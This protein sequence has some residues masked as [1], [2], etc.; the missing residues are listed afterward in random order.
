[1][2]MSTLLQE[3]PRTG[4]RKASGFGNAPSRRTAKMPH[5]WRPTVTARTAHDERLNRLT[6]SV[7]CIPT[8]DL[9]AQVSEI[10]GRNQAT[11]VAEEEVLF[12]ALCLEDLALSTD[13]A[14]SDDPISSDVEAIEFRRNIMDRIVKQN[15]PLVHEMSRRYS[16]SGLDP[17]EFW[18]E[19]TLALYRAVKRYDPTRGFRFS[20][21]AC[22]SIL[23][24]FQSMERRRH[25][26]REAL[27]RFARERLG[28]VRPEGVEAGIDRQILIG[29]VSAI[30]S[31][32]EA[33][34]TEIERFVVE[35]RFLSVSNEGTRTLA[36]LGHALRLSKQRV[37]QIEGRALA[38][39]RT[40][41]CAHA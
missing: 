17:D 25:R 6:D 39:L 31:S 32:D 30:L 24:A 5:K 8:E 14:F 2:S 41:L 18:S 26:E 29:K 1:M 28:T 7:A 19:G 10:L 4:R 9:V 22:T 13:A 12:R 35:R 21:Y 3:A 16:V 11:S 37:S 36:T 23:H 20:T 33:G 38:K 40:L 27:G 15:L 34:L